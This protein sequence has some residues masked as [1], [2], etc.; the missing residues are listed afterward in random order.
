MSDSIVVNVLS[1][2][3]TNINVN[4]TGENIYI[5]PLTLNQGVI[6]HSVT[7]QSGGSDE[8]LHNLLGG[9]QGGSGGNYYH[10]TSGEYANLVTGTVIRPS[11]TGA[12]LTIGSADPRYVNITG[13]E[14][15]S[16][17]KTFVNGIYSP[18]IS[19]ASLTGISITVNSD[20]FIMNCDL[21][22]NNHSI[23]NISTNS[24]KF[25]GDENFNT[26]SISS[27]STPDGSFR[28]I[29]L[30]GY[31]DIRNRLLV[32]EDIVVEGSLRMPPNHLSIISESENSDITV[33]KMWNVSGTTDAVRFNYYGESATGYNKPL[34]Q[35]A[36]QW[37]PIRQRSGVFNINSIGDVGINVNPVSGKDLVTNDVIVNTKL[38]I[39]TP[40][41]S[42]Q[43]NVSG[44]IF[45]NGDIYLSGSSVSQ[46]TGDINK[47]VT[48]LEKEPSISFTN[49]LY[50]EGSPIGFAQYL[51]T[52]DDQFTFVPS[53]SGALPSVICFGGYNLFPHFITNIGPLI[54]GGRILDIEPPISPEE[55]E[56]ISNFE[57]LPFLQSVDVFDTE[58]QAGPANHVNLEGGGLYFSASDSDYAYGIG[59]LSVDSTVVRTSG[60]Q[61]ISGFKTFTNRPNVNGTGVVLSGEIIVPNTGELTGVFYPL[62][63]NPNGYVTGSVVRPSE[64]GNFL[65]VNG[66]LGDRGD[67]SVGGTTPNNLTFSIDSQTIT[68]DKIA[69]NAVTTT[70]IS[71][72]NITADKLAVGSVTNSKITGNAITNDKLADMATQT[73]KGR[74]SPGISDPE[75]LSASQ[76]R[77]LIQFNSSVS[78]LLSG[79]VTGSVVRPSETG[80]F[81]T[82]AQTGAFYPV[83]NPSEYITGSVVRPSETGS[84]LTT[85]AADVRYVI[86]TGNQTISGVKQFISRPTVN[87]TGV[88]L[89]GEAV[90]VPTGELTGAFYP[91]NSNPSGYITGV[92]LSNY[93]TTAYVTGISGD[94]QQQ[95]TA[96]NNQTGGYVLDSETGNFI[97]TSQ[98]GAFYAT[99]NPSGFIT[100]IPDIVYTT[101]NQ[102]ISGLKDFQ[103]RP[104]VVDVPVLL[105]GDAVDTVH[106]Y[107][108]NDEAFTL[109]K[110]YPVFINSANGD[111]PLISLAS[112]TGERTSSKTLGLMATDVAS[113]NF[114]YIIT[115]GFLEGFDTS[116]ATAGDPMWL[117][118]TGNIIYGTGNKPYGNN[119]LVSLGIVL[120]AQSN[121]G[122]VYVKVQNGFE[123]DEL[124][125]VYAKTP[126]NKDALLYNSGS[127]AWYARQIETGDV[128]GINNYYLASNPSGFA[129]VVDPVRTTLT[130]NGTVSGYAISGAANLIN[131]SAL[132]VAID[133]ALQEPS[134]DYTV[135]SGQI[136]FTSPLPSG[137]KAVVISPS[138]SLIAGQVVPSDGSVTSAKIAGGVTISEPVLLDPIINNGLVSSTINNKVFVP[139]D[140]ELGAGIQSRSFT[141]SPPIT[142]FTD[143]DAIPNGLGAASIGTAG[144]GLSDGDNLAPLG[145][146]VQRITTGNTSGSVRGL[147]NR[148]AG[149]AANATNPGMRFRSCFAIEN[150]I[151][152]E[153]TIGLSWVGNSMAGI[154]YRYGQNNNAFTFVRGQAWIL[155]SGT[156]TSLASDIVPEAGDFVSGK[157]YIVD[158]TVI[159]QR[160][161]RVVLMIADFN[162]NN[163]TVLHD[164]VIT[165]SANILGGLMHCASARITT[166]T[167]ATRSL[168]FDWMSFEF[169]SFQR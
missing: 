4:D 1:P 65:Y 123:I 48:R 20:A 49:I 79:Y 158:F 118:P 122:K 80:S 144:S 36:N 76:V 92:N 24:I 75:D 166:R 112:N 101:G 105:S 127:G 40:Q 55:F 128:S 163:W 141:T 87:G 157:R 155:D 104:T 150:P 74:I 27:S 154:S 7:H 69:N 140:M 133:G 125:K 29:E 153:F 67:I 26:S 33:L 56:F 28:I 46:I 146:G 135:N 6:N 63:S 110:G 111:N 30:N 139:T 161:V 134:V 86:L 37:D 58:L 18:I 43:L 31:V 85:G 109:Y 9:L 19:G 38:S 156:Y 142:F 159:T 107:G 147:W 121:N 165:T 93:A 130:G 114:G 94:L 11:D 14:V 148:S 3:V 167:T 15:I 62:N 162:Q 44:N 61:T 113:N 100:G 90:S 17:I 57:G 138:N 115:E 12:F 77:T 143:F 66:L 10:L 45:V 95:I 71:N 160:T 99:S 64:T 54:S 50:T 2:E 131:P 5:N 60:N 51:K 42:G 106:L 88:M 68:S 78:G 132:I 164:S 129:T 120:R 124:H 126:Q 81:I 98:T 22:M 91:L 149:A 41:A 137:S 97:T 152:C 119:H 47:R 25:I 72:F 21:D 59:N 82:T 169:P 32:K 53:N 136:T 73:I 83:S 13:Q 89:S 96:L 145:Y 39:G 108:K 116:A 23:K 34:F 52:Y 84:F 102:D 103:T 151:D 8:L 117:G 35:I 168:W 16:G 70:K